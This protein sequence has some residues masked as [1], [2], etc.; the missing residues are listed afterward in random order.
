MD[1]DLQFNPR[2]L[3]TKSYQRINRL[4]NDAFSLIPEW[5]MHQVIIQNRFQIVIFKQ[6]GFDLYLRYRVAWDPA[7]N[8]SAAWQS[9]I[10]P[11]GA[12]TWAGF[13]RR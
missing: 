1:L 4:A 10:A 13:Q 5:K 3:H 7:S 6:D 2:L 12:K 8:E 11:K 9:A